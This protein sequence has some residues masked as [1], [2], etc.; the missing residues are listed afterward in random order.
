[1]NRR[2]VAWA[3]YS[4]WAL[5]LLL[6]ALGMVFWVLSAATPMPPGG[7]GFRGIDIIYTV[8]FSTVGP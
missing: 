6:S 5:C 7:F 3:A 1:V 4:L 8:A 2:A